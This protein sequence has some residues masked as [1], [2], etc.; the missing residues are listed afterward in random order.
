[1]GNFEMKLDIEPKNDY[2]KARKDLLKF[3]DSV[4]QLN[5]EQQEQLA[6]EY[7]PASVIGLALDFINAHR[8]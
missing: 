5:R 1:M 2:E 4:S 8:R 7:I 3:L 6:K